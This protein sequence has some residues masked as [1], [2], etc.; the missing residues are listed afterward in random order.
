MIQRRLLLTHDLN[1]EGFSLIELVV[2]I[3]V[4]SILSAI[5]LPYFV[6]LINQAI[7]QATKTSLNQSYTTC[8]QNPDQAPTGSPIPGVV[9]QQS[10][11]ASEMSATINSKCTLSM[12]MSNGV[13][14]G[15]SDSYAN[16]QV[17]STPLTAEERRIDGYRS[18]IPELVEK[19]KIGNGSCEQCL[20]G[21]QYGLGS[22]KIPYIYDPDM[23]QLNLA[24]MHEAD[25]TCESKFIGSNWA[26]NNNLFG[27]DEFVNEDG[28]RRYGELASAYV[29]IKGST[30]DEFKEN[31]AKMGARPVVFDAEGERDFLQNHYKNNPESTIKN[32]CRIAEVKL[33]SWDWTYGSRYWKENKP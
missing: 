27:Q 15:W 29:L 18:Q 11:C 33:G 9:F 19:Y 1:N 3:A 2:V 32:N 30:S 8:R 20:N 7:F 5:G 28:S 17:V 14:T 16:C 10:N 24:L 13:R 4:L 6:D 12:N 21:M 22:E 25:L 26:T 23:F 31:A